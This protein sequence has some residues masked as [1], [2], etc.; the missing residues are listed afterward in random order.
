LGKASAGAASEYDF[1][2]FYLGLGDKTQ[3]LD[4]LDKTYQ[5]HNSDIKVIRVDPFLDPLR[6]ES[7][8]EKI[9]AS[10]APEDAKVIWASHELILPG[11]EATPSLSVAIGYVI[12]TLLENE[13][14]PNRQ[15]KLSLICL[16]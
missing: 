1:V 14:C 10:L 4:W 5:Q 12:A 11:T 13:L 6:G 15:T 16:A 8:F 2:L 7:R 9:V 3:A